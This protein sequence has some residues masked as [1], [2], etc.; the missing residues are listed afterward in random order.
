MD[1]DQAI[2]QLAEEIM[3]ASQM[4]IDDGDLIIGEGDDMPWRTRLTRMRGV[5]SNITVVIDDF[6]NA[7]PHTPDE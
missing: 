5:A 1:F 2:A 7:H 6:I 3:E 4:I